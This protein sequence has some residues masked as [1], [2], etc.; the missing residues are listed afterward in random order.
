M[1]MK[2]SCSDFYNGNLLGENIEIF[3]EFLKSRG[4]SEPHW[5]LPYV[6]DA[7]GILRNIYTNA[8]FNSS[9]FHEE[10]DNQKYKGDYLYW[11]RTSA[12]VQEP[13]KPVRFGGERPING[14]CQAGC[15]LPIFTARGLCKN[16]GI[17]RQFQAMSGGWKGLE[18]S[19]SI[20]QDHSLIINNY[21]TSN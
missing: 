9:F 4:N 8:S 17:S 16:S 21:H 5:L 13:D 6:A 3:Q 20:I 2:G 19:K 15:K 10:S 7:G 11:S 12:W 18:E 14:I 1:F